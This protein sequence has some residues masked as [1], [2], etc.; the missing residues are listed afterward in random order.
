M[1]NYTNF[2]IYIIPEKGNSFRLA[3]LKLYKIF[4]FST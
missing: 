4:K 3:G 1:H 2:L